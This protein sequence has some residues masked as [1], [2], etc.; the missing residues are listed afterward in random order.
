MPT[1][2][3]PALSADDP[4]LD[5]WRAFLEAHA[6]VSRRLD[7]ELRAEHGLSLAEYDALLQLARAPGRRLRMNILAD[8]VILSRSGVTR[9]IDRLEADGLVGR[10]A[11]SSDAR[12]AEA[13][14]T[15]T[16]IHRLRAASRTH[17]R[18]IEHH[19]L[20]VVGK[21]DLVA[22][23]RSLG[24]VAAHAC[25]GVPEGT[26]PTRSGAGRLSLGR[27]PVARQA[28]LTDASRRSGTL[29]TGTSGFAYPAWSPRFY[30][31]G[32]R[33]DRLLE[34][35]SSRLAACELNNTFYRRP[36]VE[37]LAAWRDA[38]PDGF[39]FS[40]KAQ[41]GATWRAMGG[42]PAG[43]SEPIGWLTADLPTL[44]SRLGTV[45]FRLPDP[46]ARDD[47][48]L[49]AFLGAW[50]RDVPLTV[51][52]VDPSWHVDETFAALRTAGAVLC[53]TEID[54]APAPDLRVT[55]PFLYLRLR[56]TAYEADDI[57]AWADRLVPFLDD[58]LDV[59]AF[60]R[61]DETG[62]GAIR[63]MA[64]AEAVAARLA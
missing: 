7:D 30:P 48:K 28:D 40:V 37:R 9:L 64:L 5:A 43:P 19:F 14:L 62:E 60:F 44:G 11:C 56:R 61:H 2:P 36:T 4:R 53:T 34:S 31:A 29:R 16:G 58:G 10:V 45:M 1:E 52:L 26:G 25:E 6:R 41:K 42:D 51:E 39:R 55:G 54:D 23:S 33:G 20:A 17:L 8:R 12:G 59:Y 3:T 35:Y 32:L 49:G 46:M 15:Q 18:G 21:D 63:A 27:P 47:A 22:I 50:P 24:G 38:T 57:A 13:V